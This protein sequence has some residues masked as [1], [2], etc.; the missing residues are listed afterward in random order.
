MS[1][2][3]GSTATV[4]K[5]NGSQLDSL[6][7]YPLSITAEK[8]LTLSGNVTVSDGD[9]LV[10][11]GNSSIEGDQIRDYYIQLKLTKTTSSPIELFAINT[12]FA[13]SKLHN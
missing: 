7:V 6:S 11:V 13:D 1:F 10:V 8:T 5:L 9:L 4:Y 2:P 3:L 12:V